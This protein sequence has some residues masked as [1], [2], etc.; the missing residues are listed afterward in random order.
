M[1]GS[2]GRAEVFESVGGIGADPKRD[3]SLKTEPATKT[4]TVKAN[5]PNH[6]QLFEAICEAVNTILVV[7]LGSIFG[8]NIEQGVSSAARANKTPANRLFV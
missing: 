7:R 6:T 5:V 4:T 1:F 8:Q 2:F 3:T